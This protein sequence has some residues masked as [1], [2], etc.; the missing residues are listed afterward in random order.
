MS[1]VIM[2]LD[3][4]TTSSRTLLFDD[5]GK[6]VAEDRKTSGRERV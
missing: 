5:T 6:I 2:A 3:Q 4:G 1:Q